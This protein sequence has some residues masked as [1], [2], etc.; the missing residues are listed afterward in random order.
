MPILNLRTLYE[1]RGKRKR[2][3]RRETSA[4]RPCASRF[5]A[6]HVILLGRVWLVASW[7]PGWSRDQ[8]CLP[9]PLACACSSQRS[10][11]MAHHHSHGGCHDESN[12]HD[13]DHDHE[14][15]EGVGHRDN[16]F[17]RIDRAN[18]VAM[19]AEE[20]GKGP[21][22]IKPWDKRLDEAIVCH[23]HVFAYYRMSHVFCSISNPTRTTK[24][25]V[26][27]QAFWRLAEL[28]TAIEQD[29]PRAVHRCCK[30]ARTASQSRPR[31]P[32]PDE[33]LSRKSS[34]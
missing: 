33:S 20:P 32:D 7:R 2:M 28:S 8:D 12:G 13:H 27:A 25:A 18:V 24:C 1:R 15:P 26:F 23:S 19:N 9:P 34:P 30:V 21:E 3:E 16:L 4:S 31:R 17:A 5:C 6:A 11:T 22:V 10:R 29:H 14:L